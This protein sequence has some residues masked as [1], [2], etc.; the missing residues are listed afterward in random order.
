MDHVRG[1]ADNKEFYSV[2]SMKDVAAMAGVS[3]ST[4][5][6]VISG[7]IPV[8]HGTAERVKSAISS[9]DFR[10]NLLASGL[11]SKSGK[12][13]GLVVPGL[14]EPF[15]S[16]IGH[17]EYTTAQHGYSLVVGNSRSQPALEQRFVDNLIR[18]HVDGLIFTPVSHE[19]TVIDR[20]L[21]SEVPV[22]WFDRVW[23]DDRILTVRLD[24]REA[25]AIAGKHLCEHGHERIVV[26]TGPS[27]VDLCHDRLEGFVSAVRTKGE[28]IPHDH[29]LVGD[30]SFESGVAAGVSILERNIDCTAVWAQND[31]MAI[32]VLKAFSSHGVNVP[33]DV[34]IMGLDGIPLT[35]MVHPEI[36]T[37]EQPL[38]EMCEDLFS[39]IL[40]AETLVEESDRHRVFR[41]TLLKGQS[42]KSVSKHEGVAD[43]IQ[44]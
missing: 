24:N 14:Y 7:N 8:D 32:G 5:S 19:T 20:V 18:R 28:D 23:D 2:A 34:S 35:R 10:P 1:C 33:G 25:G 17:L 15:A 29:V 4:V 43:I 26:V 6:R 39:K 31:L 11:R 36:T 13:I 9:L 16:I 12:L 30:F 22:V 27:N 37:V 41:P 3:I 38:Q 21:D 44:N 42:V 40:H